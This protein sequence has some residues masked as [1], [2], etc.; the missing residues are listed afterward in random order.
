MVKALA[1]SLVGKNRWEKSCLVVTGAVIK[2]KQ[3][4]IRGSDWEKRKVG[5][6]EKASLAVTFEAPNEEQTK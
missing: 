6:S 1:V 3:V 5:W 2:S 4:A